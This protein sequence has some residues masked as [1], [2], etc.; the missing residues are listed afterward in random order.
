MT[1]QALLLLFV[2]GVHVP[3][4]DAHGD[5]HECPATEPTT[6]RWTVEHVLSS[7]QYADARERTGLP[8]N[9]KAA[10]LLKS[11]AD[12]AACAQLSSY[13]AGLPNRTNTIRNSAYYQAG[14]YYLVVVIPERNDA[15]IS[16]GWNTL[17]I[18][19]RDFN[20]IRTLGV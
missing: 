7:A 12:T 11:P 2:T 3:V 5:T 17:H 13:V 9:P 18:L 6:A 4:T 15:T 20:P 16:T 19:D 14:N 10:R 1:V 8:T